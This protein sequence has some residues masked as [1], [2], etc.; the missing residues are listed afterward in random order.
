MSAILH[1]YV[2]YHQQLQKGTFGTFDLVLSK[3]T[4]GTRVL[5]CTGSIYHLVA[6]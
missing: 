2:G 6:Q 4:R 3:K 5:L 1:A